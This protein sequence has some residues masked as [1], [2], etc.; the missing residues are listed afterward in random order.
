MG[1]GGPS[2]PPPGAYPIGNDGRPMFPAQG[3]L[4]F[5]QAGPGQQGPGQQGG[6]QGNQAHYGYDNFM[7][8][9]QQ[10]R[11]L[12]QQQQQQGAQ[13][14]GAAT[15]TAGNFA[16]E[17]E[18]LLA[19]RLSLLHQHQQEQG[20]QQG[21]GGEGGVGGENVPGSGPDMM[22]GIQYQQGAPGGMQGYQQGQLGQGQWMGQPGGQQGGQGP[23][24]QGQDG[25]QGGRLFFWDF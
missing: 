22:Q 1:M 13:P 4:E 15:G 2:G 24:Q 10:Q 19:L 7:A 25:Q 9:Q 12:Q 20:G 17:P 11:E 5:G 21:P 8:M 16:D 14:G 6:N 23:Q 18:A 3:R